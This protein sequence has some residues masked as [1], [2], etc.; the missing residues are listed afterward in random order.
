VLTDNVCKENEATKIA[1]VMLNISAQRGF[2]FHL[3][4]VWYIFNG[5]S[6]SVVLIGVTAGV[7]YV[8]DN[9]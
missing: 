7:C 6:F 4:V 8:I 1:E 2:V 3:L 5:F 9:H